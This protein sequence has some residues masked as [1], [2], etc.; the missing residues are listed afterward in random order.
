VEVEK[1]FLLDQGYIRN[2][3]NVAQWADHTFLELALKTA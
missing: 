1:Q 2:D 3:F